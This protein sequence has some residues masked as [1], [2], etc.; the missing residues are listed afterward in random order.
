LIIDGKEYVV[1]IGAKTYHCAVDIALGYIGGKWKSVVL[2]YLMEGT[3]RY[4]E[5]RRLMPDI[6]EKML[7]KQLHELQNDGLVHRKAYRVVPP[8]VEY[9]LTK[10]GRSLA[11]VL[12]ALADWGKAKSESSGGKIH[13]A[14]AHITPSKSAVQ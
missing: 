11:P 8:K 10:E 2:F 1:K 7:A 14:G 5:L 13:E 3:K 9:S 12:G 6:T 4:S